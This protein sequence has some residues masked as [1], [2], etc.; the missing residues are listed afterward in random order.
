MVWYNRQKEKPASPPPISAE[1]FPPHRAIVDAPVATPARGESRVGAGLRIKGEVE[2]G[3]DLR[4]DGR[5]EG[6]VRLAAG[7]MTVGENG[8]VSGP[9]DAREIVVHG[10]VRGR[11]C[12]T[13]RIEIGA[14]G[15]LQGDLVAD[16][17]RIDEGARVRG[18]VLMGAEEESGKRRG[19]E[20]RESKPALFPTPEAKIPAS[21][22]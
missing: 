9:I 4:V 14:T 1:P 5:I 21:E 20:P 11:L 8:S 6:S 16:R 2:G 13:D 15:V 18:R 19:R 7:R 22:Q 17:L 10:A 12:A 3:E